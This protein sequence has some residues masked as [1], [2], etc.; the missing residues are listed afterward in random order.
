[1]KKF[2]SCREQSFTSFCPP[3]SPAKRMRRN[4]GGKKEKKN[5]KDHARIKL[6]IA[7][8]EVVRGYNPVKA[9]T[10][11]SASTTPAGTAQNTFKYL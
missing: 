9:C 11:A 5:M 4:Y 3:P 6:A 7:A 2:T 8:S 1:M 10:H